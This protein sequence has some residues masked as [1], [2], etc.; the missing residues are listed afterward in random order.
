M[1]ETA[2]VRRELSTARKAA[3]KI[4]ETRIARINTKFMRNG[5]GEIEDEDENE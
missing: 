4:L 3:T 2:G 5:G 1:S